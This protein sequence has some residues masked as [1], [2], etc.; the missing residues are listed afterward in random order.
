VEGSTTPSSSNSRE[1]W[2]IAVIALLVA[3]GIAVALVLVL[4]G[5]EAKGQTVRFQAANDVG[6]QPFTPPADIHG[7]KKVTLPPEARGPFGGTGSDL[8]CDRELLIHAL[9]ARPDRMREWARV[10]G[11]T[12]TIKAVARYIRKL[13]PV[14]LTFDTRVTNHNFV[15]GRAVGYQAILAAGTAVLVDD[16]GVP[17]ARCRCGNPLLEP[18]YVPEAVCY[19]C[20]PAYTPPPPCANYDDCYKIYPDPPVVITDTFEPEPEPETTTTT[21]EPEPQTLNCNAPRSQAEFERCRDAG[22]LPEQQQPADTPA[23]ASFSPASGRASDTYTLSVSGFDPNITLSVDLV[24]PDG[25]HE[26]YTIPTNSS[27]TGSYTFPHNGNPVLGQYRATI[28]GGG[29]SATA[30][31]FVSA[32]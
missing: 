30:A 3:A 12:P 32:G 25:V 4:G 18:V 5:D 27:G 22:Q 24:R 21:E 17:R 20:P 11:V 7:K 10:L 13:T 16:D 29:E 1:R 9:R 28:S 15:G 19:G 23:S 31:T 8:V 26:S 6:D 14:T 2:L